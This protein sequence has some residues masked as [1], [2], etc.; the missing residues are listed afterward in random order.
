MSM[1]DEPLSLGTTHT[2]GE[3]FVD[4]VNIPIY[5]A[6]RFPTTFQG[7]S[8]INQIFLKANGKVTCSCMR[9]YHVLEDAENVNV[10][11]WFNG[12]M[13]EYIRESFE[14]GY[15]PFRFCEGCVSRVATMNIKA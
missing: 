11:E 14:A 8:Q 2:P 1:A 12:K 7:C 6:E 10:A 3:E 13:M 5:A 15:E 4:P 9:Y